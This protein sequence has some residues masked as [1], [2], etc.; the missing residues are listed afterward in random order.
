MSSAAAVQQPPAAI[1]QESFES[2]YPSHDAIV[3]M[4][5]VS[6]ACYDTLPDWQKEWVKSCRSICDEYGIEWRK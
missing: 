1:P 2:T 5:R 6:E 3:D 4:A